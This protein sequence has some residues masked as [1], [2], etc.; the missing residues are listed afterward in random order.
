MSQG[1][2]L[3]DKGGVPLDFKVRFEATAQEL[4]AH[5]E[6]T[7]T[8]NNAV[9]LLN[10][11]WDFDPAGKYIPAAGPAYVCLRGDKQLYLA[12]MVLPVP[13]NR[14]V[15]LRVVPFATKVEAGERY[16]ET[17]KFPVPVAEFHAYFPATPDSKFRLMTARSVAFGLQFVNDVAGMEASA[18]PLPNALRLSHPKLL[19]LIETLRSRPEVLAVPVNKRED[20]FEEFE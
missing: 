19:A 2:S 10:V 12:K 17:L 15:E 13:R 18:A 6:V 9:Y 4:I 7:N 8:R 5:Y 14:M 16:E 1:A 3:E 20:H 11:L